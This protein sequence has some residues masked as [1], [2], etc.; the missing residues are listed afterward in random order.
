MSKGAFIAGEKT[1][2]LD[3][4]K[5]E[6]SCLE[7][8]DIV[9]EEVRFGNGDA[10][11]KLN[12]FRVLSVERFA[13][14]AA[15]VGASETQPVKL[16]FSKLLMERKPETKPA[17]TRKLAA[18]LS[19]P[20][21]HQPHRSSQPADDQFAAWLEMGGSLIEEINAE[22]ELL[23]K[24]RAN[25]TANLEAIDTTHR[26]TIEQLEGELQRVREQHANDR[27]LAVAGQEA[28]DAKIARLAERKAALEKMLET[29]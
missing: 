12:K 5:V 14:R 11:V 29:V 26:K 7:K 10:D 19:H 2:N 25:F 4:V 24:Q 21:A 27:A 23:A 1:A 15:R 17:G 9:Y 16:T 28:L 20:S 22:Q 13:C 18:V 3:L 6:G 8:G